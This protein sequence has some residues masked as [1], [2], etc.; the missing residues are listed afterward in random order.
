MGLE[1]NDLTNQ[2]TALNTIAEKFQ[3]TIFLYDA[4]TGIQKLRDKN[5]QRQMIRALNALIAAQ[6]EIIVLYGMTKT[7]KQK[8]LTD[9]NS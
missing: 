2:L 4:Y 6:D 5:K 1:L 9:D 8:E 7:Q 3:R